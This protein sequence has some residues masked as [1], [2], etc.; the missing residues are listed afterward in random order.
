MKD[1]LRAIGKGIPELACNLI[2]SFNPDFAAVS[3]ATE[4]IASV[5]NIIFVDKLNRILLD[6]NE[7]FFEW[8][9][10]AENFNESNDNYQNAVRQ[11][12]YNINAINETALLSIYANLLRAYKAGLLCKDEF[13][14][15]GWVLAGIFPADLMY[16]KE[17]YGKKNMEECP[18]VK[19]LEQRGLVDISHS[20]TLWNTGVKNFYEI[21]DLGIKMLS[22]GIDYENYDTYK[23]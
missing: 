8:L 12:I 17:C 6:G 13:F 23:H 1:E 2:S 19:R 4:F 20:Q 16:L 5:P 7:D 3:R 15:L 22:C 14:R 18:E 9:K 11:L 10:I 21:S